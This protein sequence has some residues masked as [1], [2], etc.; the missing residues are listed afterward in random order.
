MSYRFTRSSATS[1]TNLSIPDHVPVGAVIGKR[2][3]YC[4]ALRENHGV[5]CSVNGDAR[6]V[7][8]KG[9]RTSIQEAE[10][11]L[12]KL[13]ASFAIDKKRVFEVVARDGPSRRWSFEREKNVSSDSQVEDYPYRLQH[14]GHAVETASV[15]TSWIQEFLEDD[16]ASV[17]SYLADKPTGPPTKVKLAFGKLC[18][19]LKS[20]RYA[21]STITWPELQ[22]LRNGADFSTRWSNYC[23]RTSP[24]IAAL[25]DDLE[26]RMEKDVEPRNSL[27]V[28]LA[29]KEG[30]SYDLKYHLVDGHWELNNAYSGRHVRGTYDVILSH[31]ASLRLRAV[32]REELS[33]NAAAG[34]QRHLAIS[35]PDNDDFFGTQVSVSSGLYV[36][37][38]E[39][40]TKMH[41][42]ANGLRFSICYLDKRQKEFR[43]ECRLSTAEKQKLAANDNDA[44]IL[45]EKALQ[46]LS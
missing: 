30:N 46:V 14:S 34:I 33:E 5:H 36:K 28:H 42:D 11:D 31:D 20:I 13:F 25:M 32:T 2:G 22:K 35:I 24:S 29:D 26:E 41:V 21:N 45:L 6:Q 44:Q 15:N 38:F 23:G 19:K 27:S 10:D 40:R 18:F 39:T 4:K 8:L 12:A 1:Q 7:T 43:L 17:M 16:V 37:S 9:P 3:S